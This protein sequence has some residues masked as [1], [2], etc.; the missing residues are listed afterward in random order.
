MDKEAKVQVF[1]VA[2]GFKKN[3]FAFKKIYLKYCSTAYWD[4][5]ASLITT[6]SALG[7]LH[8]IGTTQD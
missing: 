2:T 4:L 8:F 1:F 6:L 7:I 5:N 3:I